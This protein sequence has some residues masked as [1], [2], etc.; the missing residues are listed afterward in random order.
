MARS[1]DELAGNNADD[2][3]DSPDGKHTEAALE[4][5]RSGEPSADEA[6]RE[7]RRERKRDGD[8]K[9]ARDGQYDIRRERHESRDEVGGKH[10]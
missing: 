1:C 6:E 8:P 10:D 7:E 4:K 5:V 2:D 3:G 9:R